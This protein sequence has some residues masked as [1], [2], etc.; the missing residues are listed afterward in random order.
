VRE[1]LVKDG[2]RRAHLQALTLGFRRILYRL[3][4]TIS[5]VSLVTQKFLLEENIEA[6]ALQIVPIFPR[7]NRI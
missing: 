4:Q 1:R 3:D 7:E 2:V 6:I 5:P